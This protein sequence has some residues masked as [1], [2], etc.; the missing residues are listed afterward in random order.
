MRTSTVLV[1]LMLLMGCGGDSGSGA[2]ASAGDGGGADAA[3]A[4]AG[5]SGDDAGATDGGGALADASVSADASSGDGGATDASTADGGAVDGG[6]VDGGGV[7][8]FV[9]GLSRG[10]SADA[11][12]IVA[13]HQ[14]D[15]CGTLTA[16]GLNHSERDPFDTAEAACLA[17]YP[18]CGCAGSP[19]TTDSG[20]IATDT[21]SIQV[22]CISRGP[23]GVCM[24]YVSTRPLDGV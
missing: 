19:T 21:S 8:D 10:C 3:A 11:N 1:G 12:C 17:T 13:I 14:V 18:A 7:C 4:D 15:C 2:D 22:G 9:G 5:S 16:V 23:A 20:E 24:T 6:A